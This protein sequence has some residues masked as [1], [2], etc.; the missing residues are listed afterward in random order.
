MCGCDYLYQLPAVLPWQSTDDFRQDSRDWILD[1]GGYRSRRS[2]VRLKDMPGVHARGSD[3]GSTRI[4]RA[5]L[6]AK[7]AYFG[8]EI[9]SSLGSRPE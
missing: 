8:D 7:I 3:I 5:G 4:R 6:L 1:V 9:E 2:D